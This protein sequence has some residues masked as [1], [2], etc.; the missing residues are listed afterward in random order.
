MA[1]KKKTEI[2]NDE[3]VKVD[4]EKL[5]TSELKALAYDKLVILQSAQGELNI[6]NT[7]I[8]KRINTQKG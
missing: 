7:E 8:L 6:I 1:A 3:N 2:A 4:L 5:S